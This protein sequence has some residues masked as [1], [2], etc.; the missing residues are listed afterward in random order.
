MRL[1]NLGD[2]ATFRG[3]V[4]F[5]RVERKR[6]QITRKWLHPTLANQATKF[7]NKKT[8]V[9]SDPQSLRQNREGFGGKCSFFDLLK[10]GNPWELCHWEL[11]AANGLNGRRRKTGLD[12][13]KTQNSK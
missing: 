8:Q 10:D 1:N 11:V 12:Y 13:L 3:R 5:F 6:L 4:F 7:C 2:F 9:G